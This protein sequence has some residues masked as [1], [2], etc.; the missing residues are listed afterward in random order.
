MQYQTGS[1]SSPV[2]LLQQLVTW[3]VGIG[4]TQDR[5][6]VEGSGWTASLHKSGN[7]AHLRATMYE[8]TP[9]L[10]GSAG[11]TY[12][13]NLYLGTGYNGANSWN[14]QAGAPLGASSNPVG[15]GMRLSAGPFGNY[16]FFADAAG[17]N[18]VIVVQVTPGLYTHLG[19]GLSLNK[20]GS[21]TGGPYFF[22][23]TG[24]YNTSWTTGSANLAGLTSTTD[25]PFV[26]SDPGT[27][28]VGFVRVDVDSFT[29]KWIA[30]A[31][32]AVNAANRGYQGKQ[33]ETSV[34]GLSVTMANN[35][36]VFGY[37]AYGYQF[38]NEQ[39]SA[40]DG[41]A[42]L[43]PI[44]L[45]A[46]RDATST[47]FSLIGSVPNIFVSNAVGNGFSSADE[48][49]LGGTTYKL[50]PNFAVVKQ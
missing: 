23:S 48:Y 34:R 20:A 14:N 26:G 2:D 31:T 21:W 44:L 35:F 9:W 28:A 41:R 30:I 36:P 50:F 8:A 18:V 49:V 12:A 37:N 40:Q 7:Y 3:L 10:V 4:W 43:L 47:G 38:Q 42:N 27:T 25:C 24:G 32:A 22:G 46:L 33:G 17:D 45:W 39:V 29:G 15:V 6:A 16:Y 5:S 13:L 1:A 19:W 11:S